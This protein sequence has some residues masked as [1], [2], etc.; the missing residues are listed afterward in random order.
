MVIE[1]MK[2]R[3]LICKL[4][5]ILLMCDMIIYDIVFIDIKMHNLPHF[6]IPAIKM[7]L[8]VQQM[9]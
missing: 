9:S 2:G 8:S 7:H 5:N 1:I 4:E 6:N 3:K